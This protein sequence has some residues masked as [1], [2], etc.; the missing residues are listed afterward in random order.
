MSDIFF[1]LTRTERRF[2]LWEHLFPGARVANLGVRADVRGALDVD[3]WRAAFAATALAPALRTRVVEREGEYWGHLGDPAALE[4]VENATEA[5]VQRALEQVV[6]APFVHGHE[7]FLRGRLL[8]LSST[9]AVL[10]VGTHHAMVDGW[11]FA[12]ALPRAFGRALRG[13]PLDFDVER[14]LERRATASSVRPVD[15]EADREFFATR[16]KDVH[17]LPYPTPRTPPPVASGRGVEAFVPLSLELL[18]RV[19]AV[20]TML[21]ARPVHLWLAVVMAEVARATGS[22]DVLMA[23]TS[24]NRGVEQENDGVLA[25]SIGCTMRSNLLF[26]RLSEPMSFVELVGAAR[27]AVR[28]GLAHPH[29]ALEDLGSLGEEAPSAS[30]LLNYLPVK[31]WDDDLDGAIVHSERVFQGGTGTRTAFSVNAADTKPQLLVHLDADVFSE[32]AAA[33]LGRRL[34]QQLTTAL[35]DPAMPFS[36]WPR[37]VDE[38]RAAFARAQGTKESRIPVKGGTLGPLLVADFD[39]DDERNPR[40]ALVHDERVVTRRDLLETG[41]LLARHF[42]HRG[43]GPGRYVV[44]RIHDPLLFVQTVVGVV[45]AGGAWVPT[46]VTSPPSRIA[47]IVA[48]CDAVLV[49]N[50]DDVKVLLH[51]AALGGTPLPTPRPEDPAYAIF[52]SGSTG[53]PKGV[54]L[55]HDAVVAQLQG[56]VGLGFPAAASYLNFAPFFFDGSVEPLLWTLTTGGTLHLLDEN[57]R[58]DPAL[59][60]RVLRE[61]KITNTSAVPT[62][63]S[64]VLES[65]DRPLEDLTFVIVGGEA[66]TVPLVQKHKEQAPRA[67]FVNEYGPTESTVY[68][69]AWDVPLA[70]LPTTILIGTSAPHVSCHV[71]DAFDQPAPA[72]EPGELVVSGR[73]VADGYLKMPEQTAKAFVLDLCVAGERAYRTGDIVRLHDDGNFEWL[74]RKDDQVKVRGV[75]IELGEVEA[76]LAQLPGVLEVAAVVRSGRL[77]GYVAPAVLTENEVLAFLVGKL[78]TAMIPS[79]IVCLPSLPKSG[80]DKIDKKKLPEPKTANEDI[81]V[82]RPG[83]ETVVATLWANVLGVSPISAT[84]SFFAYGG[85]SLK[86]A[87]VVARLKQATGRDV[88]LSALLGAR[89]VRGLAAFVESSSSS[90]SSP[91]P[92]LSVPSSASSRPHGLVVPLQEERTS[93]TGPTVVFLPGIGG[94]VFTFAGIAERLQHRAVGLRAWGAERG[95]EPCSTLEAMATKNLEALEA[96]GIEDCA[97]AGYSMGARVAFEMAVQASLRGKKPVR[98]FLFD[99]MAPGYPQKL[100]PLARVWDHTSAFLRADR[101]GKVAYVKDRL[102]SLREKIAFARRDADAFVDEVPGLDPALRPQLHALWG[103]AALANQ[104]WWPRTALSVPTTLFTSATPIRWLGNKMDDPL[105][106]WTRWLHIP[107]EHIVLPGAHLELFAE[108]NHATIASA[109]DRALL[110]AER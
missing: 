85:D 8:R 108:H 1:P 84:R 16:L 21:G 92:S 15:L 63:W 74:A 32:S 107:I 82:P 39:V 9:E 80:S 47:S 73:G 37:W 27:T 81:I 64:A 55:S 50:D 40:P 6:R 83:L 38:D 14:W 3:A 100:P 24:A 101:R 35:A 48:D 13:L 89:T 75:R 19:D 52:T 95:E 76:G 90:S 110:P 41:R 57:Q 105:L 22:K 86:A 99:V 33:R 28:E 44:L 66:L 65:E 93:T 77:L 51:T 26:A 43:V 69:T 49:L 34:L 46:D 25:Q 70:P 94:H 61:R 18:E 4:I 68:S 87:V 42:V 72:G 23:T 104:A 79:T 97:L 102:V 53:K 78:P 106:G 103:K 29:F 45:F 11:S 54:I 36:R 67:R 30:T 88:P 2:W 20:A 12:S 62:L 10:V 7:P 56:R 17:P 59:V 91:L 71:L 5:D 109:L 98:L 60:R 96:S 31:A 58:K